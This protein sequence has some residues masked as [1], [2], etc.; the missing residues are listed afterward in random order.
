[1]IRRIFKED[2]SLGN[3][4][5]VDL[6]SKAHL[7]GI[8]F[9]SDEYFAVPDEPN[10]HDQETNFSIYKI[11]NGEKICELKNESDFI[12]VRNSTSPIEHD[13]K[14]TG[15]FDKKTFRIYDV[16]LATLLHLGAESLHLTKNDSILFAESE[17]YKTTEKRS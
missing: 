4:N 16:N 2:C 8:H 3:S 10:L 11:E 17:L 12:F 6:K 14:V 1:M 5:Y 9:I 13:P 15:I 7:Q